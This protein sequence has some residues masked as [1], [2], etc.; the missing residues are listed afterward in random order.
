MEPIHI[1][2][3]D[4]HWSRY[5][6]HFGLNRG[7]VSSGQIQVDTSVLACELVASGIG[8]AVIIQR[9]AQAAIETGRSICIVGDP[10]P[11]HQSHFL[12][13]KSPAIKQPVLAE[14]EVFKEW[15][16][17]EFTARN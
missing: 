16:H 10:I 12:I 3:F 8:T 14:I 2:G 4:D 5:I 6:N 11:L 9:F 13:K 15:V 7:V 1:L 17:N